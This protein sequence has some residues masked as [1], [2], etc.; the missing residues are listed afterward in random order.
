MV[1]RLGHPLVGSCSII[2]YPNYLNLLNLI[3]YGNLFDSIRFLT[4]SYVFVLVS[5]SYLD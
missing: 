5:V 3:Y 4:D 2:Q 1:W